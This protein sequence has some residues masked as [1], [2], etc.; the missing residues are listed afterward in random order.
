MRFSVVITTYNRLPLLKRAI[1][2]ALNQTV[3]C[4]VVVVDD[5]SSDGTEDYV[6]ELSQQLKQSGRGSLIYHRNETNQGHACSVNTG[7]QLAQGEWIKL[8]DDDDYLAPNCLEEMIRAIRLHPLAVICSCQS[9]QVDSEGKELSR[10]RQP[11]P[12]KVFYIP[13]SDVH[14]GMLLEQVPFG[15]PVQV[16][17][18]REAFLKSGG[19]N[20][21]LDTNCDDIDSWVKIARFGDALFINHCLAYRTIWPGACNY[22]FSIEQRM[23]ANFLVKQQIY[24]LIHADKRTIS[25]SLST[26]QNYLRLHWGL[27]A[28]KQKQMGKALQMFLPAFLSFAA[29]KLLLQ[30]HSRTHTP[31]IRRIVLSESDTPTPQ[32]PVP[33]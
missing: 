21:S 20:S 18:Q 12:G 33:S 22:R 3:L 30:V 27:V 11:G 6:Q 10:T 24:E 25:P 1:D 7:V 9:L 26:V 2:S 15:T 14:Y 4:E 8:I 29:W 19:W 31:T 16:A 13:Q 17:F 23:E 5:C 32:V 28:L